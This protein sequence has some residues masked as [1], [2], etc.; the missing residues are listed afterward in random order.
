[1]E[2]SF[3]K[4]FKILFKIF[5]STDDLLNFLIS[6]NAFKEEFMK[7]IVESEALKRHNNKNGYYEDIADLRNNL[8][9]YV[10]SYNKKKKKL[11]IIDTNFNVVFNVID[12]DFAPIEL[13]QLANLIF[14]AY[15][16]GK[17]YQYVRKD[18]W[19]KGYQGPQ[20]GRTGC[21]WSG[22]PAV[23]DRKDQRY[24]RSSGV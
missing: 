15:K 3:D 17:S 19:A 4:N 14:E 8:D 11:N 5:D 12:K 18:K 7:M 9:S 2:T 23:S 22:D 16:N 20:L 24:R 13:E 6:K 10:C 21:A 1:M